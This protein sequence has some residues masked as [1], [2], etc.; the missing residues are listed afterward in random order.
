MFNNTITKKAIAAIAA[1]LISVLSFAQ[2]QTVDDFSVKNASIETC[3]KLIEAKTGMGYLYSGKENLENLGNITLSLKGQSL[4]NVLKSVFK[5]LEYSYEYRSGVI[6]VKKIAKAAPV[7]AEQNSSGRKAAV[8]LTLN[9]SSQEDGEPVAGASCI[10]PDYGLFAM[11][12]YKGQAVIERIPAGKTR[13]QVQILGYRDFEQEVE[14]SND[15]TLPVKLFV[16]S[17]ALEQVVVTATSSAAGSST[18]SNI[19]RMAIDHLQATSLKDIMQLIPGQLMSSSDMTSEEKVTIRTLSSSTANNAF[20][21]SIM[22]DGVPMSDNTSIADKISG[23]TGGAGIDLRQISADNIE[24]VEVIRGIP[25]AEYGDLSSG[26]VVVNT[27]AGYTPFEIRT[28]VNPTTF[29][30]SFGKGWKF[31]K[32]AGSL[33]VNADYARASGDPRTKNRSYDRVSGGLTYS[34]TIG[35]NWS[36]TTK[37]NISSIVD[38]RKSDPDLL[39]EG[40]ETGQ[41]QY[42]M[43]LSHNGRLSPNKLLSRSINY[44]LGLTLTESESWTSSIVSAD[45]GLPI[46]NSLV[47]GYYQVPYITESYRATG[48]TSSKPRNFYSKIGNVFTA[49]TEHISQRFNM[50]AEYRWESNKARGYY[51]EDDFLP[52]RP[53]SNGRPRPYYDIPALNQLSSYFEDNITVNLPAGMEFKLQAGIRF[54]M[55]QPGLP[56]QVSSI[57]PRFNASYKVTDWLSFRGGWG[58]NNKTP[59]LTHLYPEP[60]Y[61]DRESA[62]YLPSDVSKR[63]VVYNTNITE[64]ERNNTLKNATN[65]KSEFGFDINLKNGM[66]FSVVAY[67]D[68]MKNGFGNLTEYSVYTSNYYTAGQGIIIAEDGSPSIDWKNPARVDTVFTTSGRIGNTNASLDRGI[69]FDFNL[70]KIEALNTSVMLSGAYMESQTWN[71]GPNYQSPSGIPA[72]SVY[73]QGGSNTPPFKLQYPSGL[74]RDINRRL[75]AN[76][77]FVCNIPRMK[78]VISASNQFILYTYQ[79]NTNQK[80]DPIGWIDTDL[81]WHPITE[82]MLADPEYRIKGILLSAQRKNP[83]DSKAVVQPPIWLMNLRLTKDVSRNFGFSFFANNALY[84][85]PFQS[86]SYSGTLTERNTGT[87]SFGLEMYI[88]I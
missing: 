80:N 17:L 11:T 45:G 31:S 10:L 56:E 27:K 30:T 18:S 53:N 1:L 15:R 37:L 68:Y 6:I 54:D 16:S 70:G 85:M 21:T 57:S 88:K 14:L 81:S 34:N 12:D 52:L 42:T 59:G 82:E 47:N 69:E 7:A 8:E 9:V 79:H 77:R 67:Q 22:V 72:N 75:S 55:L 84:Y 5:G 35:R 83:A 71:N 46:I 32:K 87:F 20:G 49:N 64:V 38:L 76:L 40:T 28:K 25:S 51:N 66:S 2:K 78:M 19:G 26:A 29:N 74:Q 58:Q 50:G 43:R 62:S 60:K 44:A 65:T 4:D 41:K 61:M 23:S 24:S 3:L 33:N 13:V 48:G 36:T 86:S 63:L 39:I 73:A